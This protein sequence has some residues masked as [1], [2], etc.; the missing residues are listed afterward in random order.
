M[1]GALWSISIA[2]DEISAVAGR[3]AEDIERATRIER[4]AKIMWQNPTLEAISEAFAR[5][6]TIAVVGLS[7][8]PERPSYGV[9]QYLVRSFEIVPVNPKLSAWHGRS[10][11]PT[12]DAV[13]SS[14]VLDM[15]VI[16]RRSE[17]IPPIVDAAIRRK[18]PCI[19]MQEGIIHEEAAAKANA[20][21]AMVVMDACSAVVHR[22]VSL[23]R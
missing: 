14:L 19:W 15:V 2:C 5:T 22:Q 18:I 12:L 1:Y 17:E 23:T 7:D 3:V 4:S 20:A 6:K 16:F 9:T 10:A 21:G 11:F 8:N 13:P